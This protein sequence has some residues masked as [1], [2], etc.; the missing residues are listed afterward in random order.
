MPRIFGCAGSFQEAVSLS[1][2]M[3][4]GI[5]LCDLDPNA[6]GGVNTFAFGLIHGLISSREEGDSFIFLVTGDNEAFLRT[7][8]AAYGVSFLKVPIGR[9]SRYINASLVLSA[10]AVGNF[11][12]RY[13]FD[14]IF[15]VPL[16]RKI[17]KAIDVLLAPM[18]V[19]KFYGLRTP[20]LLSIHDIQQE[21]HPEFFSLWDRVRRWAPYRLSCWRAAAIQASS[22][23][24][25]GCLIEKF[26]FVN[27]EKIFLIPEGVDLEKF[28]PE[29]LVEM[30]PALCNLDG[31]NFIFYPAQLWP[32]KN[33]LLLIEALARYRDE[34]GTEL[35]CVLTGRDYGV[36]STVRQRI[37]A[38]DLKAVYYLGQVKFESLLWLYQ[39]CRA[40]LALG[41]HE[42]SSLPMREGAV[43]GK[44]LI[45]SD[46]PPN[47]ELQGRLKIRLVH[48]ED[49]S[50]LAAA[51]VALVDR[52]GRIDQ[53]SLENRRLARNFDWKIIAR[54]YRNALMRMVRS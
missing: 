28:S 53:V 30:P 33:H 51:L 40:V 18:T 27:P 21:Y 4:I 26:S 1:G 25:K 52:S 17:D 7:K 36:F 24:I 34:V 42:S 46:I 49:P 31:Q 2:H 12:L 9:W 32:H 23:Y 50:D 54:D 16:M 37:E 35:P 6:T 43:F 8:F 5:D 48:T 10:W 19:L 44:A 39:N 47:Q 41:L 20:A 15:R 29:G 11:K 22:Q 14:R 38:L 13:V 3:R 45:C